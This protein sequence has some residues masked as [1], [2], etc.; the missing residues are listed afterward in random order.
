M[1]GDARE[2]R[3]VR[4]MKQLVAAAGA[5]RSNALWGSRSGG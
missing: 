5:V 2:V 1:T 4:K 3:T